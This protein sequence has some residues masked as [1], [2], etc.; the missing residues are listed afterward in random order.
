MVLGCATTDPT[1]LVPRASTYSDVNEKSTLEWNL[2]RA[3]P[4]FCLLFL[5]PRE[6]LP[7]AACSMV[8]WCDGVQVRASIITDLDKELSDDVRRPCEAPA[9]ACCY[10]PLIAA[11]DVR[12]NVRRTANS[13]SGERTKV[14]S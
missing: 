5:G 13:G 2:V 1:A 10:A 11:S 7:P 6:A 12:R 8:C 3:L 4:S 14:V 9:D